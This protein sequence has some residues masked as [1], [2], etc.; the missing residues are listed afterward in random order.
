MDPHPQQSDAGYARVHRL[1]RADDQEGQGPEGARCS[2]DRQEEED[3]DDND[4]H[5]SYSRKCQ[6]GKPEH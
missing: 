1:G 5:V 2:E 4:K 6:S 3:S